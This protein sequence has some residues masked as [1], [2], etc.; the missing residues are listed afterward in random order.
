DFEGNFTSA[1][2]FPNKKIAAIG[3]TL[4]ENLE[5]VLNKLQEH[6]KSFS[7]EYK[8]RNVLL[9]FYD[10]SKSEE[11]SEVVAENLS[12]KVVPID[13]SKYTSDNF[14]TLDC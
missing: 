5:F 12:F 6:C 10:G 13:Y 4:A 1:G 2:N 3:S 14:I 9:Y 7:C 11:I 8:P